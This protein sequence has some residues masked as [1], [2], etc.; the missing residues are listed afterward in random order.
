MDVKK[1][2]IAHC[3]VCL[4]IALS[5]LFGTTILSFLSTIFTRSS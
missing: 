1:L 4:L 2:L 3:A 5:V